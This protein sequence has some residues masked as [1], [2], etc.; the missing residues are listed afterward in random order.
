MKIQL[1]YGRNGLEVDIPAP[2]VTVLRPQFVPGLNDERAAFETAVRHP[3]QSPPLADQIDTGDTV[4]IV[5]A[6]ITRAL[7]SDR[8]LPWLL[9]ELDHVSRENFTVII[10][11]GTHRACTRAEIE[12]LVGAEVVQKVRVVNHNAYDD[13][14]LATVGRLQGDNGRL[15]LNKAYVQADKRIIIGFIE[16]HFMAGFSGGYK[17]VFPGVAGL[18]AIMH[19]HRAEAIGHPRSSWGVLDGNP[20][21]A[22]IRQYGAVLPVDFCINVTLNHQQ[23]ITRFFCGE[24]VAAH[25]QGCAFVKETAMVGCKR[26]FPIVITSNSGYPLDQN[27][28]QTVKGMCAAAEI[29][30][31]GG[32]I[33]TAARC[34]DGFPDH[35]NFTELLLEHDS[36]QALLETIHTPGF[37]RLDQWQAQK[38][39]Q[40]Q[41]KARVALYSDIPATDLSRVR[42]E[43]IAD[44][45]TYLR[46][47]LAT[48]GADLPIAVLPEGPMTIPYLA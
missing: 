22:Q 31:S 47:Q 39:A 28:Y 43:P 30:T 17:A 25:E 21:Q 26:P 23:D 44:I 16:P 4:A 9:A 42:I 46:Q 12:Q 6:D 40:V 1:Q 3:I 32:L 14:L 45:D 48:L 29:V 5:I 18:S 27:L 24:V 19:Y 35:G 36:P 13:D 33:I 34:N 7:P 41:L 20:T 38:L 11:T 15:Q 10:G 8:L 37:H 2:D